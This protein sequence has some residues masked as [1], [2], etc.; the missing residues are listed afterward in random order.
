MKSDIT[1][2]CYTTSE[3]RL[4]MRKPRKMET[5]ALVWGAI[6]T[7]DPGLTNGHSVVLRILHPITT[8]KQVMANNGVY[9]SVSSP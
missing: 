1:W 6:W 4:E 9:H 3:E 7:T 2:E 5:N 8:G